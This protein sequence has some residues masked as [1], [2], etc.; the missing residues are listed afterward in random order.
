MKTYKIKRIDDHY[1]HIHAEVESG[2]YSLGAYYKKLLKSGDIFRVHTDQ[3]DMNIAY[4]FKQEVVLLRT[5]QNYDTAREIIGN[6]K[7][8]DKVRFNNS[9]VKNLIKKKIMPSIFS[10]SLNLF[11]VANSKGTRK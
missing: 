9:L 7:W 10:P 11:I 5:V 8:F 1:D 4:S 6:F 2:E 3:D